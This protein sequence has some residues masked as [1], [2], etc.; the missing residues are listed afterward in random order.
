MA[1]ETRGVTVGRGFK[2]IDWGRVGVNPTSR[3]RNRHF[4]VGHMTDLAVVEF[5]CLVIERV[6]GFYQG[7]A[8]E[9]T[10]LWARTQC[11]YYVLVFVMRK[12]DR[13][14]LWSA[15]IAEPQTLIIAR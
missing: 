5:L 12:L 6:R 2:R 8:E 14:L 7:S 11:R 10:I 1:V 3:R 4:W 15:R 13:E 9:L